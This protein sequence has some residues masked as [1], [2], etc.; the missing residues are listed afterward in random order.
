MWGNSEYESVRRSNRIA[1]RLCY[2]QVTQMLF[3]YFVHG[4]TAYIYA[5]PQLRCVYAYA[6]GVSYIIENPASSLIWRYPCLRDS[7]CRTP[8]DISNNTSF[9]IPTD[10]SIPIPGRA[11]TCDRS[12]KLLKKHGAKQISVSLGA[13]GGMTPK[14]V[15]W[16]WLWIFVIPV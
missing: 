1:R 11:L 14:R 8:Y 12:K 13:F 9:L 3:V 10:I 15:T 5:E 7:C 16:L 6:K 4:L 2:L